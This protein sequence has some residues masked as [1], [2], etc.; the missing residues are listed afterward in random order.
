MC[1]VE[2]LTQLPRDI[3]EGAESLQV[4]KQTKF[5]VRQDDTR[6]RRGRTFLK[7]VIIPYSMSVITFE[8]SN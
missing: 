8:L 6:S 2:K 4:R 1:R 5:D 3:V 7:F